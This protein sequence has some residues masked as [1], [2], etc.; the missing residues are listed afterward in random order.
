MLYFLVFQQELV[1]ITIQNVSPYIVSR[2]KKLKM[3]GIVTYKDPDNKILHSY[4][5]LVGIAHESPIMRSESIFQGF[6]DSSFNSFSRQNWQLIVI[7]VERFKILSM[8]EDNG[9]NYAS[10][11]IEKDK[12][13]KLSQKLLADLKSSGKNFIK[14]LNIS[15]TLAQE[16]ENSLNTEQDP[17]ILGF[18]IAS[19]MDIPVSEK[20][21]LLENFNLQNRT[22]KIIKLTS[23][24]LSEDQLSKDVSEKVKKDLAKK[25]ERKGNLMPTFGVSKDNEIEKLEQKLLALELVPETKNYLTDELQRLKSM[26]KEHPEFNMMKNYLDLA[27]GLPWNVSS[28]D[29]YDIKNAQGVLDNDHFGLEKVKKRIIEYIAVRGLRGDMKGSILCFTGPPGVGKTSM[30]KSIAAA[31]GRKFYRISLGGVRDE[32]EI[33]GHRRTYIGALPGVFISVISK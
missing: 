30:G 3:F 25:I 15:P 27:L 1:S 16:K 19:S 2:S 24:L 4:G 9:I 21:A 13:N 6:F 14:T 29:N 12:D 17:A 32:A 22:E 18:I 28:T 5:T 7:G 23:T 8:T 33:R 11:Q 31:I 26:P 10:I 20:Q